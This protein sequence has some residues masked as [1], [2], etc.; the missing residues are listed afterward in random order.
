VSSEYYLRPEKS[1][2]LA[3]GVCPGESVVLAT[4]GYPDT[5]HVLL[6]SF[7]G[8]PPSP[9]SHFTMRWEPGSLIFLLRSWEPS[10]LPHLSPLP[11]PFPSPPLV[12]LQ[13]FFSRAAKPEMLLRLE[14]PPRRCEGALPPSVQ[15]WRSAGTGV[16]RAPTRRLGGWART[17]HRRGGRRDG[18]CPRAD[19]DG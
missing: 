16:A 11:A 2:V 7:V 13:P 17:A 3:F 14:R 8:S 19:E 18:H 9:P 1:V 10:T 15:M 4:I 5:S 12:P 6:C